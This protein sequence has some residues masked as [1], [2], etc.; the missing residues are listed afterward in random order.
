MCQLN[1]QN[2][3]S[4]DHNWE[5][6]DDNDKQARKAFESLLRVSLLQ[7]TTPKFHNFAETVRARAKKDYNYT[8]YEGEEVSTSVQLHHLMYNIN[9]FY[10]MLGEL[11]YRSIL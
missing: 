8:F 11:F 1:Q 7:P 10:L 4:A 9:C 3:Y 2:S 6:D 5:A